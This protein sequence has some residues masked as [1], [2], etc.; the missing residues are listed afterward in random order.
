[1]NSLFPNKY[2]AYSAGTEPTNVHPLAVQVMNEAGVDI[3]RQ[4]AKSMSQYIDQPFD[5]VVTLCDQARESCPTFP[6][7]KITIHR[8]FP[9]PDSTREGDQTE[10]YRKIRDQIKEFVTMEFGPKNVAGTK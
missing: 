5:I 1:M 10:L 6:G 8:D 3:S 9:D 2:Q 7:A 4:T